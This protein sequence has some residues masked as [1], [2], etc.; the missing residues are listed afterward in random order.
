[1]AALLYLKHAHNKTDES[2][3]VHWVQDVYFQFF[4]GEEYFQA[5]MPCDPTNLVRFRQALGKAGSREGDCLS[6]GQPVARG[7]ADQTGAFSAACA[8][9]AQA[10]V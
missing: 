9:S 5:R 8:L 2:V 10:N 3:C 7:G 6:D 1:M 4:C